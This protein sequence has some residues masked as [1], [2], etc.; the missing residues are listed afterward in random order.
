MT[1]NNEQGVKIALD[2]A[3][4]ATAVTAPAWVQNVTTYGGVIMLVAGIILM[5][6]RVAIA[7]RE[8]KKP[9]G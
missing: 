4:G 5:C 9:N 6:L 1:G 8:W 2:S 7:Y 3:I